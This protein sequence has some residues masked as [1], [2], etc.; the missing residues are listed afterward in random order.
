MLSKTT[1]P[2]EF[3][4]STTISISTFAE[5]PPLAKTRSPDLLR[6]PVAK[7]QRE[8][9]PPLPGELL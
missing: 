3:A 8:L 5:A 7:N 1:T 9:S 6:A 2:P 4:R